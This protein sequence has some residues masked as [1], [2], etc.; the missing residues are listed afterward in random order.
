VENSQV[1]VNR[2]YVYVNHHPLLQSVASLPANESNLFAA[3]G[4][5]VEK[6]NS[7]Y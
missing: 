5:D 3:S 2:Q 7:D 4:F 1:N 6:F